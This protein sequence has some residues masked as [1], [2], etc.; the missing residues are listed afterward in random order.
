MADWFFLDGDPLVRV[1]MITAGRWHIDFKGAGI[2][3]ESCDI[4]AARPV[5]CILGWIQGNK[6]AI[7][8]YL[9]SRFFVGKAP[10]AFGGDDRAWRQDS[11]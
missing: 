11:L 9:S 2:D 10:W 7:L 4:R 3:R 8:P 1:D 6:N 5:S